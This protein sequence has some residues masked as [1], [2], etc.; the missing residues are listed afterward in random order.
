MAKHI[1]FLI[2]GVGI[3]QN[4]S[5]ADSVKSKITEVAK[6]YSHF[7]THDLEDDVELVPISYDHIFR[8]A[9][10]SWDKRGGEIR[11]FAEDN[12]IN[13]HSVLNW[14]DGVSSDDSFL[15]SHAM[16]VVIYYLF[17][18]RRDKI[19]MEVI[20]QITQKIKSCND[21]N[22]ACSVVAHSLGTC[23]VHDSLH[24]MGTTNWGNNASFFDSSRWS[25]QLVMML[26]NTS[27]LLHT[28]INPYDSIVRPVH[29][30]GETSYCQ[31]YINVQHKYDPV[32]F[33]WAYNPDWMNDDTKIEIQ[34]FHEPNIHGYTHYLDNPCVHIP[35]LRSITNWEAVTENEE[36]VAK[37]EYKRFDGDLAVINKFETVKRGLEAKQPVEVIKSLSHIFKILNPS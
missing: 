20:H 1:L 11:Q 15:W 16:D 6:R 33:P 17:S 14:L 8:E 30:G 23:V 34:H 19:R 32:P 29:V 3:H 2:H 26:A 24:V 13:D 10:E 21:P 7:R 28:D 22:I 12:G 35:L 36:Q 31:D 27:R 18:L 9:L 25:F 37:E 4:Q 5:W